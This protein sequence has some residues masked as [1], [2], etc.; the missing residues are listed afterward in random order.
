MATR[1]FTSSLRKGEVWSHKPS[2]FTDKLLTS[3]TAGTPSTRDDAESSDTSR[4]IIM[5]HDPSPP[6]H[7]VGFTEFLKL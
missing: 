7:R 3:G 4:I 2:L 1:L 6:S 5:S